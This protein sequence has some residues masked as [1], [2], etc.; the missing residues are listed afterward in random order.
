MHN[1]PQP[2]CGHPKNNSGECGDRDHHG[3]PEQAYSERPLGRGCHFSG[4]LALCLDQGGGKR[5]GE[6]K[7]IHRSFWFDTF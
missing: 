7:T 6:G 5:R 2:A 1:Q 3:G 4:Y